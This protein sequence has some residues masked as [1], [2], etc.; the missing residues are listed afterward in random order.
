MLLAVQLD[1]LRQERDNYYSFY[2]IFYLPCPSAAAA[3]RSCGAGRPPRSGR[4]R[5]S[6]R[7][8]RGSRRF[9]RRKSSPSASA[10]RRTSSWSSPSP[11]GRRRGRRRSVPTY[12]NVHHAMYVCKHL[13]MHVVSMW[14]GRLDAHRAA[15]R[16][17]GCN[18]GGKGEGG[19]GGKG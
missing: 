7:S 13:R 18:G 12:G 10:P 15:P 19:G 6:R 11:E 9:R 16:R 5:T 2:F 17:A 4:R 3:R 1:T 14:Y 8:R